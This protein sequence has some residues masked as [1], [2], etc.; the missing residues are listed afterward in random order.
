MVEI[1]KVV[2]A[3]PPAPLKGGNL[4]GDVSIKIKHERLAILR[5]YFRIKYGKDVLFTYK[6]IKE[7]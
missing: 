1:I 3:N 5:R 6:E 7:K 4:G 2:D